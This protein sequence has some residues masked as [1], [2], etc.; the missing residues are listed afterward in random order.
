MLYGWGR[1]LYRR[2]GAFTLPIA[3]NVPAFVSR[4]LMPPRVVSNAGFTSPKETRLPRH[5]HRL[6]SDT[7]PPGVHAYRCDLRLGA[8]A[9]RAPR[10][11]PRPSR[12][13]LPFPT[14]FTAMKSTIATAMAETETVET[15][16]IIVLLSHTAAPC[17]PLLSVRDVETRPS[18]REPVLAV[19]A[20]S[21]KDPKSTAP[22]RYFR[23]FR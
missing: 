16:A 13:S 9:G 7:S 12:G 1:F 23:R 5:Y 20:P 17:P 2:P 19:N 11:G 10:T 22:P 18:F 4:V 6:S 21:A 14:L 3:I 15:M 8:A